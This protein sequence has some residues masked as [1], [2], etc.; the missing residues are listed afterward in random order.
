DAKARPRPPGERNVLERSDGERDRGGRA[1]HRIEHRV[2]KR[3]AALDPLLTEQVF[4]RLGE[5]DR[6]RRRQSQ[7]ALAEIARRDLE[8]MSAGDSRD[9]EADAPAPQS[10]AHPT[11]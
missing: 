2:A 9:R 8:L 4:E 11:L 6:A 7:R 3:P 10:P 1:A 5:R